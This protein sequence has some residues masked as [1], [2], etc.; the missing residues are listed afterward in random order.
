M[1]AFELN[2]ICSLLNGGIEVALP[3]CHQ[4]GT[5]VEDD[6]A[7]KLHQPS[8]QP[9]VQEALDSALLAYPY[10]EYGNPLT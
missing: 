7:F 9:Q 1:S 8:S 5:R 2:N 10:S 4:W 3:P 6:Y